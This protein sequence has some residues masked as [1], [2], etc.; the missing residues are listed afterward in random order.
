MTKQVY[1]GLALLTVILL[2]PAAAPAKLTETCLT[3]TAPDVASDADQIRAT[4]GKVDAAC[5]CAT[6]DASKGKGRAAYL[7]CAFDIITAQAKAAALRPQCKPT[8]KSYYSNST[9]GKNPPLHAEPCIQTIKKTG[10]ITCTIKPLTQSNGVTATNACT[11]TSTAWRVPCANTTLCIDAADKNGDLLI[12][13]PGDDGMCVTNKPD[14]VPTV[15][16]PPAS[17]VAGQSISVSYTVANRADGLA[18]PGWYDS[19]YLS[20]DA[21]LDSGDIDL[22]DLYH[23][24]ALAPSGATYSNSTSLTI[25][26]STAPGSYYLIVVTDSYGYIPESNETNN[27]LAV[28]ITIT[29]PDLVPT[30]LTPPA[31]GVA[32]QSISVSYTV[33]NQGDGS[34]VSPNGYRYDSIYLSTDAVWDGGDID[35]GDLYQSGA[36]APLGATYSNTVSVPIPGGTAPGSYYLIVVTDSYGWIP[37]SNESNNTLAVAI[38]VTAPDLVPTVL[39]PPASGVAGQSISVSYTVANQG[40]GSAVSPNGYWYDSIYLSTDAVWDSGDIDLGDLYQSGVV[41]PLGTYSNTVSVPIPGGTAPGSYYLI[42]G[43]D[44]YGGIPE[45]NETNNTLAV[46]ITVTSQ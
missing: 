18:A 19:I 29:K 27:T 40:D 38:T 2:S 12:A 21:V 31:S 14:L 39:T 33:A 10:K 36:L 22:T 35:L 6:F 25:P 42:V 41:A 11:D 23:S 13:A 28:P 26:G 46:A 5:V 44:T 8:V 15:L 7:K 20:T 37:E 24:G 17:G 1:S 43:T 9:C 34:A 4:R 45:S 30:V 32:G 3:G 16:T